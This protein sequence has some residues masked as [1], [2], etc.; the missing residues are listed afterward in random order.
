MI[1]RLGN[2]WICV[3]SLAVADE[4]FPPDTPT[5]LVTLAGALVATLTVT[6]IAG[7]LAPAANA[8]LR[9]QVLVEQLQPVPVMDTK[10]RPVGTVSV[11][12]TVP[13]VG[14]AALALLTV[15]V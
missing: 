15:T 14:P 1:E 12:V 3:T 6:V 10:V 9:V 2:N 7:K 13:L 8:V 4:E 5:W 11:T